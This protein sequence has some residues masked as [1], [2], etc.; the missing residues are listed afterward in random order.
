MAQALRNAEKI[1]SIKK[2]FDTAGFNTLVVPADSTD[3]KSV[4]NAFST[5]RDK[6]GKPEVLVY[7]AGS[8]QYNS[9]LD[10][11][12]ES[13][14]QN[15]KAN[16]MGGFLTAK[17]VLADM[18][19]NNKGTILFT[20]A[21]AS[22]RGGAN[23]ANLAVGKFGLRALAQSIAREFGPKGVHV[24]HVIIDGQIDNER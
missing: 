4:A 14:E 21:T 1:E 6:L 8:F 13:F 3:P 16:C 5:I 11:T 18:S 22:L 7:N 24:S 10:I 12:P 19:A 20:G 9:I 17:E 2:D 23:F 15:W